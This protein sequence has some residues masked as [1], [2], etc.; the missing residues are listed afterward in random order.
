MTDKREQI[1]AV[2]TAAIKKDGL[3]S[4]SFRTLAD[5]VGVKSASVHYHFPTKSD[6]AL[7]VVS[8]YTEGFKERL[9]DIDRRHRSLNGKLNAFIKIFEDVLAEGDLCLCGIMASEMNSL[10]VSTQNAL[11]RFFT[12]S[13]AWLKQTFDNHSEEWDT[14]LS[15]GQLAKILMSGLEG[16]LLLDRLEG[17]GSRLKAY[18]ALVKSL[19]A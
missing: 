8:D 18:R 15:S 6:L 16:G 5:E 2:A 10:D 7:A 17:T 3:K 19:L 11:S 9:A 13:E 4:V 12:E 14:K 1:E